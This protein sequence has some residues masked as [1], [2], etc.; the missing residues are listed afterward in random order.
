MASKLTKQGRLR[1]AAGLTLGITLV[2]MTIVG[3]RWSLS[4]TESEGAD[5]Q[6]PQPDSPGPSS[7]VQ[8]SA[9]APQA[10][11]DPSGIHF[12]EVTKEAGLAVELVDRPME[13]GEDQSGSAA[14]GDYDGDGDI[15]LIFTRVGMPNLLFRNEGDGTFL[16]VAESQNVAQPIS[17]RGSG[18]PLIA[19]VD[20]DGLKDIFLA[21]TPSGGR[22]LLI[23]S[24]N[25]TFEDA[26]E[27]S[28]LE[29]TQSEDRPPQ[30]FGAAFADWDN[31][32]DLDLATVE[33][34]VGALEGLD[35]ADLAGGE[36]LTR[37]CR[38][39]EAIR[40][41][42]RETEGQQQS[43]SKMYQNDGDGTFS[44]ITKES[45]I[46]FDGILGFNLTFSDIDRDG[47][48]DLA[49]TGDYCTSRL[50]HNAGDSSFEDITKAAGVG[51]D[52]NG[53]GSV[54]EDIDGD[55]ILDWFVT[56]I[57]YPDE[58]DACQGAEPGCAGNRLYLGDGSGGFR[59]ATNEFGVRDGSWGWGAASEDFD[60][61][62]FRDLVVVNGYREGRSIDGAKAYGP[63]GGA[64]FDNDPLRFWPGR[65]EVP[66]E[67]I[68]TRSGVSDKNGKTLI[69]LDYDLDGD[70][71]LLVVNT[72]DPPSLFRNDSERDGH[73]FGLRLRQDGPNAEA[74]GARILVHRGLGTPAM[75]SEVRGGGTMSGSWPTERRFGVGAYET[76]ERVEVWWPGEDEPDVIEHVPTDQVVTMRR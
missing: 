58:V 19:D 34:F 50:F 57:E 32:G 76:L 63:P 26:T 73:W 65:P 60:L 11:A 8:V 30:A 15:D 55:G 44:D 51:L 12:T 72:E 41:V 24:G 52:Q 29:V 3:Q 18:P 43:L 9:P 46:L 36:E 64:S 38:G 2:G 7:S 20:G 33:W 21:G 10:E 31:D 45:G 17:P 70:S 47:L 68:G 71:D 42:A 59:D 4:P 61:D 48:V 23:N 37:A 14:A 62:G 67:N 16:E 25:Q 39:A 66:W 1:L 28:G 49:V 53:M 13:L 5:V 69:S 75:P 6:A 27:G 56:S 35:G 22:A 54:I 40:K 74:I